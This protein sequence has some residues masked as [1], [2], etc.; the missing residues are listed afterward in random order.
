MRETIITGQRL[1]VGL[2]P[3]HYKDTVSRKNL[4]DFFTAE[5]HCGYKIKA[6][7]AKGFGFS[8]IQGRWMSWRSLRLL[9]RF[10]LRLWRPP[11]VF[12]G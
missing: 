3:F 10:L 12:L 1:S 4:R 7:G 2:A 9:F 8:L 6:H 5:E 11:F